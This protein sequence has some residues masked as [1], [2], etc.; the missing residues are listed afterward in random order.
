MIICHTVTFYSKRE[1]KHVDSNSDLLEQME[2]DL[3]EIFEM[4]DRY[5]ATRIRQGNEKICNAHSKAGFLNFT[6][7]FV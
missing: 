3:Y 7:Y 2:H 4:F 1:N 6:N 5:T